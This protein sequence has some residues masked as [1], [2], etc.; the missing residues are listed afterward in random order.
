MLADM[1]IAVNIGVEHWYSG[2]RFLTILLLHWSITYSMH[3]YIS[4]A[5]LFAHYR[6]VYTYEY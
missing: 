6:Q 4:Y 1:N 2:C 5:E 3:E